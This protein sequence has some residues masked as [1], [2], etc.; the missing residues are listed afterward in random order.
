MRGSV[1]QSWRDPT[2]AW[3][4]KL[5]RAN[6]HIKE[7]STMMSDFEESKAYAV[8]R[9]GTEKPNV[10]AFRFTILRQVPVQLLTAIGDAVHNMRSA[11]DSVAYE[12]ARQYLNDAMTDKQKG[13]TQFPICEAGEDFDKFFANH[14]I[15]RE[16]YGE[17]EKK[18]MRCVQPF[19]MREEA[20]AL[21]VEFQ[22]DPH[23]EFSIDE[24]HRLHSL[25]VVDKHR[26]LPLLTWYLEFSYWNDEKCKWGYAQQPNDEFKDQATIGYLEG[27]GQGPP[28]AEVTFRFKLALV[29]DPASSI[30]PGFHD[31]FTR[32]LGR[33][34]DYL[35]GWVIPRIFMVAEGNPP[36]I[37]IAGQ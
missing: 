10:V 17:Q 33:W 21:G 34:H 11:L 23:V 35:R 9:E 20:G 29:D 5:E 4:A 16:M 13:A 8:R 22:T 19:A 3:W 31:D 24:L 30:G 18:A 36:P 27:P 6:R 12:L 7:I 15:R 2:A 25:S 14:G 32:V 37:F 1:D 28:A 26:R